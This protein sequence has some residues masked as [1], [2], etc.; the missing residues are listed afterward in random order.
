MAWRA[1]GEGVWLWMAWA[2]CA[3]ALA[4]CADEAT[5]SNNSGKPPVVI[6][7]CADERDCERGQM[8][9]EGACLP[10]GDG[11]FVPDATDNCP[12]IANPD[13][14]DADG[15]G[16]GDL[17]E[18]PPV[19]MDD[20]E[21][22]VD[23]A[24]DNCPGVPNPDQ[25]DRDG[26][27]LGDACDSDQDPDRDGVPTGR[28]NCPD[29]ANP[30]Q[31]DLDGDGL[32]DACDP[33]DDNDGVDDARDNC[34]L[35]SNRDQKD[36]DG[37]GKGDVCDDGDMDG[38][39]D[40][41]DNC[42]NAFNPN[43]Q[44]T[45]GD[46]KGDECDDDIDGDGIKNDGDNSGDPND[47]PCQE[48][49]TMGCDDNC[50]YVVNPN[51]KDRDADGTGD[52]CDPDNTR[53]D[54]KPTNP[55]CAYV[56]NVG[57]FTPRLEWSLSIKATDPYPDRNQVMMTPVV[58]NLND[59]N[60]DGVIDE[61]DIPDVVFTTFQTNQNPNNWDELRYGVLRAASGD[62][63]GL[64]WSVGYTELGFNNR[65]GIQPAG[66]IAV[67]DIDNDGK[68]EIIAGMWND[69]TE[70]GGMVAVSNTGAVKWKT[71]ATDASGR[72]VP[73]QFTFWW[74]GPAIADMDGDGR[75]EIVIGN[76]VFNHQG[77]LKWNGSQ[78]PG[79]TGAAGQGINARAGVM[80]PTLYTGQLSVVADLDRVQAGGR[81]RQELV[82]GRTAYTHDG[83]KLW[84]ADPVL[85]DGFPAIGD[86]NNDGMPEVVV[87]ARGSVRIHNGLTGAVLWSVAVDAS[88]RL[89]APTVADFDG[90]GVPEIGVAG[91]NKYVA[92]KVN[93]ANPAPTLAAATLWSANTKDDSSNMTGSSVFDF[94]GDGRAEVVYNDEEFLRVYRGSDGVVLYQVAN[95]S[96]TALEYPIIVDIDNDG[97]AEIVVGTNDFECGDRL[98]C[99][100]G[101]AGLRV[102]GAA[103]NEWVST[104]RV[105]NQH[106]YHIDNVTELGGI[107]A[108][109]TP[110][111]L[112]HNTY[113][114]NAQTTIPPQAAPDLIGEDP[115]VISDGCSAVSVNVWITNSGAVRVGAGLPVSF[116]AV[117]GAQR[118]YLGEA[119]TRLPLEPGD[120]ERVSTQVSLPQGGPWRIEAVVD[121]AAGTGMGTRNECNKANN[122]IVIASN[123]NCP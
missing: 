100:K 13:Q 4:G 63:T 111:W 71:T 66:S 93:L 50:A 64:L 103:N 37:D 24:I 94:E 29:V 19:V 62:G 2:V 44:D 102:F 42:P 67:G 65:G 32:G 82:T 78:A 17:C 76:M 84:E 110:S 39:P 81:T 77:Q 87:S 116:Y 99:Q 98:S 53:L 88:S 38:R 31:G 95:T 115:E 10:D 119:K 34:P 112:S 58:V 75:P 86:F 61:R 60:Q 49:Q 108:Q 41:E 106:S 70:T 36:R 35:V 120:S 97:E 6:E 22:G 72:L 54:G 118:T 90:D 40:A 25:Q 8:C 48:G 56:R 15:D 43:Q 52:A 79:L 113:R 114:L 85:P 5:R 7:G 47:N 57:P 109:E 117:R 3:A 26:D 122:T 59:D 101:F 28:D 123:I 68:P 21:D 12:L 18:P 14:A 16:T 11:D 104:R 1:E 55:M 92:L 45:D 33:D 9:L 46:G 20:D 74:G 105:W 107:P 121:D 23:D 69:S 80:D 51:Q 83:Q 73:R 30:G 27:G 89:G 91:K 96:F